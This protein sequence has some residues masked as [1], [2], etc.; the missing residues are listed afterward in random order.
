MCVKPAPPCSYKSR[1]RATGYWTSYTAGVG[2][3]NVFRGEQ[4]NARFLGYGPGSLSRRSWY[5]DPEDPVPY[6]GSQHLQQIQDMVQLEDTPGAVECPEGQVVAGITGLRWVPPI[7]DF[8]SADESDPY[9][10]PRL[11]DITD[12][13]TST[14]TGWYTTRFFRPELSDDIRM[15]PGWCPASTWEGGVGSQQIA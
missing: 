3:V 12:H 9:L 14:S 13:V 7:T 2:M 11:T 8:S 6:R 1:C 10:Y 5:M 4:A 15:N